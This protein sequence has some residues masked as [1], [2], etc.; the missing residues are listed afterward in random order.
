MHLQDQRPATR[1]NSLVVY[2]PLHGP[3]LV[4]NFRSL[5]ELV[6]SYTMR[7]AYASVHFMIPQT[8]FFSCQ[9]L[10]CR[11]LKAMLF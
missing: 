6:L 3:F 7:D 9:G 4:E 8:F 2:Y 1:R 5:L 11:Y 10:T